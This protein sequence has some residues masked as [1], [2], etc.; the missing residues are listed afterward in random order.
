M[1]ER[2]P[3]ARNALKSAARFT[4]AERA[5][6]KDHSQERKVVWGKNRENDERAVLA[7]IAQM[8][9]TDR[10][11]GRRIHEIVGTSAPA[12][13]P[14]LWYGMP[15]YT[16]DGNVLCFFQPAHRFKARYGSLG[17]SDKAKLDEG[18]MWP[19]VYAISE[20]TPAEEASMASLV[21]K[22]MG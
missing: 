5:A 6:M 2:K 18:R 21:E 8:P 10:T 17:F 16:K 1:A 20:L 4:D 11:I 19:I 9:G 22:A 13:S 3:T 14:R 15:A 7:K 12:L